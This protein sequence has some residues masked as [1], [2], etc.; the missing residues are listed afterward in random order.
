[1]ST[2]IGTNPDDTKC[3]PPGHNN[4]VGLRL[5]YDS[6]NR[7]S[8]FSAVLG[9]DPLHYLHTTGTVHSFDASAPTATTPK[10]RDSS[11]VNFAGGN[12]W[13]EIGTWTRIQ[14]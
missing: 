11:A 3:G 8:R 10:Q 1:M 14:P 4:A 7:P 13:K 2:R 5:Y 6:A 9:A 12:P